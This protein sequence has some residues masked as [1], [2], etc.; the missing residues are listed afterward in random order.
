MRWLLALSLSLAALLAGNADAQI[1]PPNGP[2]YGLS[3][4]D[5][6]NQYVDV[7]D[8]I[9]FPGDFTVEGWVYPRS[10]NS[11]SR[12]LDFGNV[13]PDTGEGTDN[14]VV[15]LT[16]GTTGRPHFNVVRFF[17][18][19]HGITAPDALPLNQWTHLA[20]VLS[21]TTGTIYVNGSAVASGLMNRPRAISRAGCYLGRSNWARDSYANA[22]FD[23]VRIWNVARTAAQI[24]EAMRRQLFG[25]ESGL[26]DYYRFDETTGPSASS[27]TGN[28]THTATL[29][30]GPAWMSVIGVIV[31]FAP[32][33][34]TGDASV[35]A[36]L[37]ATWNGDLDERGFGAASVAYF[38]WGSTGSFGNQTPPVIGNAG[39]EFLHWSSTVTGL[40]DNTTYYFRA[41]GSNDYGTSYGATRMFKVHL[42]TTNIVSNNNNTG[43]GSLRQVIQD[44]VR[45]DTILFAPNVT[46]TITLTTGEIGIDQDLTIDASALAN[47]ITISGNNTS[48]I[49]YID[50]KIV[51]LR[52]LTLTGGNSASG[53]AIFTRYG[54]SLTLDHCIITGNST[55]GGGGGVYC[56]N[57]TYLV[58]STVSGN[59]A[60]LFGGGIYALFGLNSLNSTLSGNSAF[61][62]GG[63]IYFEL[64]PH[65]LVNS[66]LFG[67]W[68]TSDDFGRGGGIYGKEYAFLNIINST[69]SG[70]FS[71]Y[72]GG[73]LV[74]A[75]FALENSIVTGN[76]GGDISGPFSSSGVNLIGGNPV[77][78]PLG[79]YGGPTQT[80]PPLPGSPAL[81]RAQ[82]GIE[83]QTAFLFLWSVTLDAAAGEERLHVAHKIRRSR[84][85][86]R[87]L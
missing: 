14:V 77:L 62:S 49:F 79:D 55:T 81:E 67:N 50:N 25:N 18:T 2:G 31:P 32:T 24:Q 33:V 70:N 65:T 72:V 16:E 80:M 86:G 56:G 84:G 58:N 66:T 22:N 26:I 69:V 87:E 52:S 54:G 47:G 27:G 83:A 71:A 30:N 34:T 6:F 73:I 13:D 44:S 20:C 4:V 48:R 3:L 7:P 51:T 10:Y 53:G 35:V 1:P 59:H 12:L 75:P 78:A 76:L 11:W 74:N 68:T 60:A 61:Y 45:G 29:V 85:G 38:E 19:S 64:G 9:W 37:S 82:P 42:P 5:A 46:N 15:A 43:P 23:E 17:D 57:V 41:V 8:G 39:D 21:G 28:P 36:G 40:V 63:G